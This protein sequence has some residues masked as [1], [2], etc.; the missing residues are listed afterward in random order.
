MTLLPVIAG[1]LETVSKGFGKG[2]KEIEIKGRVET[3]VSAALLKST[4]ILRRV[5]ETR[6]YLLTLRFQCKTASKR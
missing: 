6:E 2:P 5:L 1:V 4:R 3:I